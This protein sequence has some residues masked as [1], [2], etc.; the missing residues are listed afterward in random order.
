MR[1]HVEGGQEI[2]GEKGG[3]LVLVFVSPG[4]VLER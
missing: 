2:V 3:G 1:L 4:Q